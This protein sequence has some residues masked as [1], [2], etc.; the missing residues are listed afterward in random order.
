M[1][2]IEE[3]AIKTQVVD[4]FCGAGGL[5]NGL[6]RAGL[7]VVKGIDIDE[8]CKYAY[9]KN[10]NA[11]FVHKSVAD[12]STGEIEKL[13][14]GRGIK[15]LV[16][17]APCQTF[18]T[19]TTKYKYGA[20]DHRWGL[21]ADFAEIVKRTRP[22]VVSMENVTN[23][24][25]KD[26]FRDFVDELKKLKYQVND[27]NV[28]YCP[29]YAIPQKRKRL[30]FLA[31]TLGPIDLLDATTPKDDYQTVR[32]AISDIKP[33]DPLHKFSQLSDINL[34]RIKQSKPGGTWRDWDSSLVLDCHKK[35]SG[36]NYL[37][38]YGRMKWDE[39]SPTITT[40]FYKYGTGRFGHPEEDR[41]LSLK[42][43]AI[44]QSFPENYQFM[45]QG[46]RMSIDQIAKLIGNAVPPKLGEM[47]GKT[48][49]RHMENYA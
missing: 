43:G 23:L 45:P 6:I 29:D 32:D 38:V 31:S 4:L 30:V 13:F 21:L 34:M 16:G 28:V 17:C 42:E 24:R 22:A 33:N 47:I 10:N 5:T 8:D 14:D 27:N 12:L 20:A 41:A 35:Q 26:I 9:E 7:D 48:I 36:Q 19:H 49:L 39:P 40:K 3:K 15:V 44:L 46:K 25:N 1:N 2:K 18:S 11:R 37:S